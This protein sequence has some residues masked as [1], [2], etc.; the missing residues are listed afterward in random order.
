MSCCQPMEE[1][2]RPLP[3]L[4]ARYA[5]FVVQHSCRPAPPSTAVFVCHSRRQSFTNVSRSYWLPIEMAVI[6]ERTFLMTLASLL[7]ACSAGASKPHIIQIV[8]G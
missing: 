7:V 1:I 8:G 2:F 5:Y 6:A 4:R 3:M